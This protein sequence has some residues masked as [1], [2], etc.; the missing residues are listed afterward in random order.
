LVKEY[1]RL[2]EDESE[3]LKIEWS[4]Q[5]MLSKVNYK[6]HTDSIKEN[7]IPRELGKS[8][9]SLI[10]ANEADVL[11]MALFGTTAKHWRD[12]NPN[13]KGNIRDI[14]TIQQLVVLS[15]LVPQNERLVQLNKLAISQMK[16]L[17]DSQHLKKL[18]NTN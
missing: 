7:L 17:V 4:F 10:Y 2:K 15:N 13:K 6:I 8:Q 11:N 12:A 3:R 5:R 18:K 9:T 16:S 1:Q 14:A